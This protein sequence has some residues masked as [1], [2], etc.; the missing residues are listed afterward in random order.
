MAIQ[1]YDIRR[2]DGIFEVRFWR[3]VNTPVFGPGNE[4]LYIIH[5]VEDVT[6]MQEIKSAG[7]EQLK[8]RRELEQS[9]K[10]HL[11]DLRDSQD[12][13]LKIFDLSPVVMYMTLLDSGRFI[14]VNRAFE[15]LFG[16]ERSVVIGKNAIEL[17]IIDAA[18]RA[19]AA[20]KIENA[21]GG[22]VQLELNMKTAAG[23]LIKALV[24]TEI[25]EMDHRKCFLVALVDITERK[26]TEDALRKANHFLD[27]ILE[28]I[29][30][31]GFCK[32]SCQ[33]KVPEVQ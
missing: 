19:E 2:P 22:A 7:E 6:E 24:S 15:H 11:L 33:L 28:N 12:R 29:P 14:H 23:Q 26:R 31:Y 5:R 1:K 8:R 17:N 16:L 30:Q 4:V 32:G 10:Q 13:F 25:L 27:T 9:E 20:R 3:P 21:S 18:A